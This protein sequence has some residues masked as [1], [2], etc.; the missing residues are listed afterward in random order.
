[1]DGMNSSG[2]D[3]ATVIPAEERSL[4][5]AGS[6]KPTLFGRKAP[7]PPLSKTSEEHLSQMG[8]EEN[9]DLS[10]SQSHLPELQP[11]VPLSPIGFEVS[12]RN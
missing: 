3:S 10:R 4:P 9:E 2:N 5:S 8:L 7:P 11:M 12:S 6:S 1:M